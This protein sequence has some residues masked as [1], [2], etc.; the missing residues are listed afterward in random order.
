MIAPEKFRHEVDFHASC[1]TQAGHG[2][3]GACKSR[4]F[5]GLQAKQEIAGK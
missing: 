2:S 4:R 3:Q 5:S 1:P